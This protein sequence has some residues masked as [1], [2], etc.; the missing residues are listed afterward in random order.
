MVRNN[1]GNF[2]NNDDNNYYE[3]TLTIYGKTLIPNE[4]EL[5]FLTIEAQ[6]C[7]DRWGKDEE[8]APLSCSHRL[9]DEITL[10]SE[11][12]RLCLKLV[13]WPGHARMKAVNPEITTEIPDNIQFTSS[14][15]MDELVKNLQSLV[16]E[17]LQSGELVATGFDERFP[18]DSAA[19]RIPPDRWK[20][21]AP[22]FPKSEARTKNLILQ[23]IHVRRRADRGAIA[24][25][26]QSLVESAPTAP[27]PMQ[28]AIKPKHKGGRPRLDEAAFKA[29]NLVAEECGLNECLKMSGK[30]LANRALTK[31]T[32]VRTSK[33][34]SMVTPWKRRARNCS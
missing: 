33:L 10:K 24:Q 14:Y 20:L 15:N 22:D 6:N 29:F 1:N 12:F 21:L 5:A 31:T 26:Y 4:R 9:L 27:T 23:D 16:L 25:P 19:V 2:F 17:K 34:E 28:P 3:I 32:E 8:E 7:R 13:E 18:I 30:A 11:I